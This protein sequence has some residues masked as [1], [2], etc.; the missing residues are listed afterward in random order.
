M[1]AYADGVHIRKPD[2]MARGQSRVLVVEDHAP[3]VLVTSSFL[4]KFG[5][6][7]DVAG[8]GV[9]AVDRVSAASYGLILMD[10]QMPGMN[11][12]DATRQIRA[13]EK[14]TGRTPAYII[15]MTAHAF[16]ADRERCLACGMDD[17]V[18]KPFDPEEF[19]VKLGHI[20][21]G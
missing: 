10:V 15:G 19:K 4:E 8:D 2:G 18:A 13:I 11:G 16:L 7:V 12:Y 1:P 17:Y 21:R 9:E 5:F 3:N 20:A 14:E 6:A